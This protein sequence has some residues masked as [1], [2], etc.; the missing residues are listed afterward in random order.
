M[1]SRTDP[2]DEWQFILQL[3]SRV[4]SLLA[5]E[6]GYD[7]IQ[8]SALDTIN[9][10]LESCKSTMTLLLYSFFFLLCSYNT[11][12]RRETTFIGTCIC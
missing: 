4:I 10:R 6:A 9:D 1:T 2:T 11:K 12:R 3:Q 7:A 8:T 5:K